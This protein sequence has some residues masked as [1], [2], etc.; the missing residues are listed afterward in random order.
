MCGQEG[1]PLYKRV[2]GE[3]HLTGFDVS[4]TKNSFQEDD[5]FA[6]FIKLLREHLNEDKSFPIFSQGQNY[7]KPKTVKE[8]KDIG[9]KLVNQI[10]SGFT[11]PMSHPS[12]PKDVN[13]SKPTQDQ[14]SQEKPSIVIPVT[15][16][17]QQTTPVSIQSVSNGFFDGITI[18]INLDNNEK[19]ELTIK[20]GEGD[21]GLYTFLET[22]DHKYET[23][24]NLKN[25]VFQ[26]FADSLSTK[27]GQEQLSYMIEVM[28]A[29]EISMLK[30]G[31]DAATK[32]RATF[33]NLFGTI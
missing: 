31:S 6:E 30:G 15:T 2:F 3:L 21:S 27:E 8:I 1:S 11:K 20:V 5:D 14:P 10:A 32:F 33:N 7:T 29:S 16:A 19:V 18:D 4:F 26:R 28:V 17:V 22:D 9:E 24:I 23:T 25:S 13:S 12:K